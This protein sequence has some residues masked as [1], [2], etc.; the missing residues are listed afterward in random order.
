MESVWG[1]QTAITMK[2][3]VTIR[4]EDNDTGYMDRDSADW[5][6]M[7]KELPLLF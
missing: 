1:A 7:K 3:E 5:C 6:L 2:P 4:I